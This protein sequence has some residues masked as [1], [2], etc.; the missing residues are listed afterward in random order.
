MITYKIN[1]EI[2]LT[3]L[4]ARDNDAIRYLY[5]VCE[6]FTIKVYNKKIKGNYGNKYWDDYLSEVTMSTFTATLNFNGN[7][8]SNYKSYIYKTI[9]NCATKIVRDKCKPQ[10]VFKSLDDENDLECKE[11]VEKNSAHKEDAVFKKT[12]LNEE[13][14]SYLD[15][16]LK[17]LEVQLFKNVYYKKET[18]KYFAETHNYNYSTIR[19]IFHRMSKK[20]EYEKIKSMLF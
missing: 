20:I 5:K 15:H 13:L 10:Y 7:T 8:E 16:K 11:Y 12:I 18:L 4:R 1:L 2:F 9:L 19:S 17:P 3:K 14:I 6:G